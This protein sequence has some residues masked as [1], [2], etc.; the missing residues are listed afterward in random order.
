MNKIKNTPLIATMTRNINVLSR[1]DCSVFGDDA[2]EVREKLN[3]VSNLCQCY[4][5]YENGLIPE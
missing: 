4:I 2:N 1:F 5:D 3:E